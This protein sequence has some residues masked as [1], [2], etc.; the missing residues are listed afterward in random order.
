MPHIIHLKSTLQLV[1][2]A[3]YWELFS[4]ASWSTESIT[5]ISG[6]SAVAY[7]ILS[8]KSFTNPR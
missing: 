1:L 4:P 6:W 3:C 2:Q 8:E 5:I 7:F